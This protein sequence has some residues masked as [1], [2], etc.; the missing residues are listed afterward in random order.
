MTPVAL[1]EKLHGFEA[2]RRSLRLAGLDLNVLNPVCSPSR[3]AA[4]TRC[5]AARFSIHQHFA[6]P[7]SNAQ[8]N[9]PD[10]LDPRATTLPRLLK[11]T[12]YRTGHFGKWH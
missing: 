9:M 1:V 7:A 4:M 5:Y 6:S 2:L 10:W 8:R 12:G 3:T 11:Q